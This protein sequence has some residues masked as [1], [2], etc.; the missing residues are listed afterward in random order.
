M[1]AQAIIILVVVLVSLAKTASCALSVKFQ[2]KTV[3]LL[4]DEPGAKNRAASISNGYLIC[5]N[6]ETVT[7]VGAKRL[8]YSTPKASGSV[9]PGEMEIVASGGNVLKIQNGGLK[10]VIL[11]GNKLAYH[12]PNGLVDLQIYIETGPGKKYYIPFHPN[13]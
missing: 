1:R 12:G 9:P 5:G 3:A 2:G 8:F 4:C 6:E 13:A 7:R 10:Q 11:S